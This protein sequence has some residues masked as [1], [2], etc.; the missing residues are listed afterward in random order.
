MNATER[1]TWVVRHKEV[2]R[3]SFDGEPPVLIFKSHEFAPEL[4]S[5]CPRHAILTSHRCARAE[6]A[7]AVKLG[8]LAVTGSELA[9][10][11]SLWWRDHRHWK[12]A[13]ALDLAWDQMARAPR[14]T[15][16]AVIRHLVDSLGLPRLRHANLAQSQLDDLG[17]EG[18]VG[19]PSTRNV[20]V[21]AGFGS[22]LRAARKA[23]A[24]VTPDG[25]TRASSR[26]R[27]AVGPVDDSFARWL[28]AACSPSEQA[29][30]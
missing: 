29:A 22:A 11:A 19:I 3:Q 30:A 28:H 18:N 27:E 5:L 24:H 21:P 14:R 9:R 6:L 25:A 20:R 13:G 15:H 8:W 4:L 10:A 23:Q 16:R 12:R 7:S 17:S 2:L 1:A 26:R